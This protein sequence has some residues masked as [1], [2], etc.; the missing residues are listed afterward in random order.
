MKWV[1][2]ERPKTDRI[3]CPWLIRRFI[4]PH[5]EISYVPADQ[6]LIWNGLSRRRYCLVDRWFAR[7]RWSTP[8]RV[9]SGRG[10]VGGGRAAVGMGRRAGT[11]WIG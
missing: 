4:D 2:R 8:G 6:V 9:S 1:T 7:S 11:V 10:V 3:A 5:S